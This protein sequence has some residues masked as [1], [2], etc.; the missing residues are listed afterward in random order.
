MSKTKRDKQP[1][2]QCPV[3]QSTE[4]QMRGSYFQCKDCGEYTLKDKVKTKLYKDGTVVVNAIVPQGV[5]TKKK[6]AEILGIDLN[7][8]RIK[9][10]DYSISHAYR[11]DRKGY[12]K[13]KDGKVEGESYDT[14]K[15][16]IAPI[17]NMKV[18]LEERT[19]E[20]RTEEAVDDILKQLKV[21][22]PKVPKL[23]YNKVKAKNMLEVFVPDIHFGRSVWGEETG[24]GV[25]YDMQIAEKVTQLAIESILDRVDLKQVGRILFPLGNDFYNV[26]GANLAT[27]K[28]TPQ[29]NDP[30]WRRT[31]ANGVVLAIRMIQRLRKIAPVDILMVEGNHDK[32]ALFYLGTALAYNFTN[33]KNITVDNRPTE[34]KVYTWGDAAIGFFHGEMKH[35]DGIDKFNNEFRDT[36]ARAKYK[37]IH[38]GHI[39]HERILRAKTQ[40]MTYLSEEREQVMFR[41]IRA[42]TPT[43]AWH[44]NKG[45]TGASRGSEGFLW[46]KDE[47][48][49]GI[50]PAIIDEDRYR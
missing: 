18:T 36:F 35:L 2:Y 47:G 28:G 16:L 20:R 48:L 44:F 24:K 9:S 46:N 7:S 1:K 31:F 21:K 8:F 39:H 22:S 4:Y 6:V 45:F 13:A 30:H 32:N 41:N 49:L 10:V 33:D 50:F 11:K 15:L 12:W 19:I 38:A 34:R 17:M 27:T 3:C 23:K 29:V 5:Y 25:N 26:D 42:L 37:E 43:D 14:G 40:R